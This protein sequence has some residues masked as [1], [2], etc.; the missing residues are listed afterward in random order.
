MNNYVIGDIM[1]NNP[2]NDAMILN[3]YSLQNNDRDCDKMIKF[4]VEII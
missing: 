4:L 3:M 2:H 1:N